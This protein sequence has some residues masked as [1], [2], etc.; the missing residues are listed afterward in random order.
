MTSDILGDVFKFSQKSLPKR[1]NNNNI[2]IN[3]I[4]TN[5]DSRGEPSH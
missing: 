1:E 4:N 5:I 2:I 3:K